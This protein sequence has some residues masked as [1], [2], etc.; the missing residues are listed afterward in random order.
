[1]TENCGIGTGGANATNVAGRSSRG[2]AGDLL[3]DLTHLHGDHGLEQAGAVLR[4]RAGLQLQHGLGELTLALGTETLHSLLDLRELGLHVVHVDL[5]IHLDDGHIVALPVVIVHLQRG[6]RLA[7]RQAEV[8][9]QGDRREGTTLLLD[10][11]HLQEGQALVRG[12]VAQHHVGVRLLHVHVGGEVRQALVDVLAH[13]LLSPA[14]LLHVA[15][16]LPVELH[17]VHNVDVDAEVQLGAGLLVVDRVQAL[18]D[19][20]L[21]GL[22]ELRG[23]LVA[24]VVVVDRLVH[25]LLLLQRLDLGTHE[26]EVVLLRVQGGPARGLA[27]RAVVGVV[28]IQAHHGHHVTDGRVAL[29]HLGA[30]GTQDAA[31]E[32]GLAA[33]GVRRNA[34]DH[35]GVLQL[36]IRIH[37]GLHVISPGVGRVELDAIH[38]TELLLGLGRGPDE[39]SGHAHA[40]AEASGVEAAHGAQGRGAR[41][42]EGLLRLVQRSRDERARDEDRMGPGHGCKAL[43]EGDSCNK[44]S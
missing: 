42:H 43:R 23:V 31:Q 9:L 17:L 34:D 10:Q 33:A 27:A 18:E 8:L 1:M 24:R 16:H 28:V 35:R 21:V 26:R 36:L 5:A 15:L 44:I 2:L 4:A 22:E 12:L 40:A 38:L 11:L 25:G 37:D 20:H 29:D 39:A 6:A 41:R 13:L 14:A 7:A 19:H 3:V 32:G 30:Q